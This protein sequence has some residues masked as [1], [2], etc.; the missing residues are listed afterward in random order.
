MLNQINRCKGKKI[1]EKNNCF[2]LY[3]ELINIK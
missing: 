2:I 3:L 1:N